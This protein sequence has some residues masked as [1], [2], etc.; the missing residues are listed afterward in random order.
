VTDVRLVVGQSSTG[1][2]EALGDYGHPYPA[3]LSSYIYYKGFKNQ[4]DEL[5][6]RDWM[7]DSGAYSA[8]TC[9][10]KIDLQEYID[11]CKKVSN[12]DPE[13]VEIIAL[14]VIG[15]WKS[16]LENYEEMRRQGIEAIPTY[17]LGEPAHVLETL[18]ETYPK[19]A[20]SGYTTL[21]GER[22]KKGYT[23]AVFGIAWKNGPKKLHALGLGT[24]DIIKAYP[25]HSVD[26]SSWQLRPLKFGS[27]PGC[28]NRNLGLKGNHT[29][30]IRREV[31]YWLKIERYNKK[32]W[33]KEL[34]SM[35]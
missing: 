3:L 33:S 6:Y 23:D 30:N 32:V 9:G 19:V 25:W 13:L 26:A 1:V 34:R 35:E 27:F 18:C 20:I 28:G 17:H 31:E 5:H 29:R 15:D 11:F 21:K 10:R 4:Q 8:F 14:D 22:S 2:I 24:E 7:L 12:E 16:S